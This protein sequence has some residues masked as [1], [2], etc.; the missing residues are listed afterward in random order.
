MMTQ[1]NKWRC[2]GISGGGAPWTPAISPHDPDVMLLNCDMSGAYRTQDGGRTWQMLPWWALM[3]CPFCAPAF[4]Q[5]RPGVVYAAYSYNATLRV[6]HDNGKTWRPAEG[7]PPGGL[8]FIAVD[9]ARPARL[10]ALTQREVWVGE[11]DQWRRIGVLPAS[12]RA[13]WVGVMPNAGARSVVM[14]ATDECVYR[15]DESLSTFR[16][17]GGR[18]PM[19]R[20]A[21]AAFASNDKSSRAYVWL[22]CG[23]DHE[24]STSEVWRSN[25]LGD[26]W[27]KASDLR[28]DGFSGITSYDGRRL[29][30][31]DALPE[32][33]YAVWPA[34]VRSPMVWRSDD[35]ASSWRG[36]CIGD[37]DAANYNMATG[38]VADY[39]LAKSLV[40]WGIT[41]A[42]IAP[43]D[44]DRVLIADYCTPYITRNGGETWTTCDAPDAGRP[45]MGSESSTKKHWTNN[46]LNVTTTWDYAIDPH[47]PSRH[48]ACYTDVGLFRSGDGG[49]SWAWL[50]DHGANVYQ[51]AFDPHVPGRMWAALAQC[52]DIP[53]NNA[54]TGGH[55][56]QG[57]GTVA[58]SDDAGETWIDFNTGE[59]VV[60]YEWHR[61][62][63]GAGWQTR[64][65][66]P[67]SNVISI[68]V[69]P[70]SPREARV[71]F[72]SSWEHGVFMSRDGGR[73]WETRA[74]GLGVEGVNRRVC[75]LKLHRDGSLW[76]LV[77]GKKREGELIRAGVGLYR[78]LDRGATWHD[79]TSGLDIRW[80]TDFE[81][82]P[83]D[84]GTVYLGVCDDPFRKV[85]EGGLWVTRDG[86]RGWTRSARKSPLHFGATADPRRPGRVYMTLTYND[87]SAPPLWVSED[88][89]ETWRAVENY[90]FCSA[91]RVHFHPTDP[92]VIYVTS[93]GG[94]VLRGTI[95]D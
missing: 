16:A 26:T 53:N 5:A 77:T 3:G 85:G 19:K 10:Y 45:S 58:R 42:A 33:V 32:R 78:S 27:E 83:D 74:T 86:G 20:I 39:F 15:W 46:G 4:D 36:V 35:S 37:K 62:D 24:P 95:A 49:E 8:R 17:C 68:V 63:F 51:L 41:A 93:Y 23:V 84:S 47:D 65:G 72:A 79:T 71:L 57:Y 28:V 43:R 25:D 14:L 30:C 88:R 67:P 64:K 61:P 44:P 75:R 91:H 7:N 82:D 73:T 81:L 29:L 76:C 6:S 54:I 56:T 40:G 13:L 60:D 34:R 21:A 92:A 69:D 38:F 87:A 66:L 50:R 11:S 94:G 89:G 9:P 2:V 12:A 31:S 59:R 55:R 18:W 1:E 70:S 90:P 52:H 80:L 22:E 48:F